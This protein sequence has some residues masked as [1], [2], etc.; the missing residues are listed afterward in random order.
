MEVLSYL[1]EAVDWASVLIV[2]AIVSVPTF[3][4]IVWAMMLNSSRFSRDEEGR[5]GPWSGV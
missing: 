3:V 2:A 1:L 5:N 4:A